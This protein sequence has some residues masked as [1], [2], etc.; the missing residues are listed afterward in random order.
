MLFPVSESTVLFAVMLV[1]LRCAPAQVS[2]HVVSRITVKVAALHTVRTWA[3]EGFKDK[4]MDIHLDVLTVHTR[5]NPHVASFWQSSLL[6]DF[7]VAASS[8]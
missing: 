1:L 3:Y 6:E 8:G 2:Q 7:S 5:K 4:T